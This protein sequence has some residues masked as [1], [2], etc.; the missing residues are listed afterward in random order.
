[1]RIVV[2]GATGNAGTSLLDAFERDESVDSVLGV[3]RRSPAARGD[4]KTEWA[5][6]GADTPPLKPSES[7]VDEVVATRVGGED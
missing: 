3:A 5:R 6:A 4:G 2:F 7:R 1:M